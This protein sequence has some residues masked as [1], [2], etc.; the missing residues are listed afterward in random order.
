MNIHELMPDRPYFFALPGSKEYRKDIEMLEFIDGF[1]IK[2]NFECDVISRLFSNRG[3]LK[4]TVKMVEQYC[5]IFRVALINSLKDT[6]IRNLV[7]I[8][9]NNSV[10]RW[11]CYYNA[12]DFVCFPSKSTVDRY[13]H[14]FCRGD[15]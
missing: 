7:T 6:S 13:L 4:P 1:L 15:Y 10:Y 8:S 11:F 5:R 12:N 3:I 2:N 9:S 14:F